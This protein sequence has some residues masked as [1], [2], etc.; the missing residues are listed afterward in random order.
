MKTAIYTPII[1]FLFLCNTSLQ[2]QPGSTIELK[3][4][5]QYE[6]R[7]LVSEKTTTAKLPYAKK[8]FQNTITHYNYYFNANNRLNDIVQR[9]KAA[10]K[11]SYTKL[12]AFYNYSLD[13]TAYDGDIDSIIY[14][15]NAGILLHDLRN[16]W[17]DDLYF[18]M[19][20]AYYFR[21]DFDSSAHV[22]QY[23]NYAFAPKDEGYDIPIG[24]NASNH[25]GVFSISEKENQSFL[26]KL[27]SYPP[28][29]NEDLLWMAKNNIDA[30]KSYEAISLLEIL[31]H[32]PQF[33]ERLQPDLH[34]ALA[35]WFYTQ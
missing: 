5:E 29:R 19:G 22:F 26:K 8:I 34:E 21:K 25:P 32:D 15:C 2:A 7:T 9:A 16:D 28:R 27:T 31:R 20:K 11:E 14:K 17:I 30:G 24:S 4:P 35:Y 13:V 18:L 23:I 1:F 6:N 33:P 10:Y 12:L 3:K